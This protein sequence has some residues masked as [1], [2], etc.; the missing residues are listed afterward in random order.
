MLAP[1]PAPEVSGRRINLVFAVLALVL[2]EGIL[3]SLIG[4]TRLWGAHA[5][6]FSPRA[7]LVPVLLALVALLPPVSGRLAGFGPARATGF[8]ARPG[9]PWALGALF[10]LVFWLLRERHLFW[11]DALPLSINVPQGQAFHADEPLT[12]WIQHALWAA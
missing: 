6:A 9:F 10:A 11:G 4:R 2:A 7:C 12:L 8:A 3:E 1:L 5:L